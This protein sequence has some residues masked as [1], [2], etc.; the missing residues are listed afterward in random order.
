MFGLTGCEWD[1]KDGNCWAYNKKI[2]TNNPDDDSPDFCHPF[3]TENDEGKKTGIEC[4]RYH[5]EVIY[6]KN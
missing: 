2:V 5:N 3:N 1:S 4:L 6:Q